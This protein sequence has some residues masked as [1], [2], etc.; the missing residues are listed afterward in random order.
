MESGTKR[1]AKEK[2]G[3]RI[4]KVRKLSSDIRSFFEQP[5]NASGECTSVL[6]HASIQPTDAAQLDSISTLQADLS[7][8]PNVLLDQMISDEEIDEDD[9]QV[10]SSVD[11]QSACSIPFLANH[12][13]PNSSK[14]IE[15]TTIESVGHNSAEAGSIEDNVTDIGLVIYGIPQPQNVMEK[16]L[17]EQPS[18]PSILPVHVYE[19]GGK[20]IK[21]YFR[22]AWLS[23]YHWLVWSPSKE[24]AY[25]K[26]CVLFA[27]VPQGRCRGGG[28]LG[29]LVVTPFQDFKNAKGR[30]GVLDKHESYQYH[31]DAVLMGK[32]FLEQCRN[33]ALR[34]DNVLDMQSQELMKSNRL[35][36]KSI[37]ECIIFCG[38]QGISFRGHRDDYTADPSTNKGN[39][40]ALLEFRARTDA[41]LQDFITNAPRNACYTS[42]TIQNDI[43]ELCGNYVREYTNAAVMKGG[44]FAI[45]AD[46]VTDS[47]NNHT[48]LGICNRMLDISNPGNVFVKEQLFDFVQLER[49]NSESVCKKLMEFYTL[50]SID[51]NRVRAQTYD[52]TS[53]MS[54]A[55]NGVNGRFRASYPKAIY[56]PC[57][58]HI[59]N[60]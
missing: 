41:T 17:T 60:L 3:D 59:L 9:V 39:F 46:E 38:K 7:E 35:A 31:K 36:L 58:A 22:K 12:T 5:T 11:D 30:E 23:E 40:L 10:I 33:P 24:G 1:C 20:T 2:E 32:A 37:V 8:P 19:K 21:Q 15:S 28:V 34:I 6:T 42:K 51:L 43:I 45:I 29:K 52:T 55:A 57:N 25:C 4:S 47:S 16:L 56:L 27:K 13:T 44:Y 18:L 50:H 54:S 49:T 48:V 26:Y 53:S 14:Q